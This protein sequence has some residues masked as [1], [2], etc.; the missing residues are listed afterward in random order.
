MPRSKCLVF[1]AE[2]RTAW[3]LHPAGLIELQENI[4]GPVSEA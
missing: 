4:N 1:R 3:N 2:V